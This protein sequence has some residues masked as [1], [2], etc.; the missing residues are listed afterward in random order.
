MITSLTLPVTISSPPTFQHWA[1]LCSVSRCCISLCPWLSVLLSSMYWSQLSLW[2]AL[3]PAHLHSHPNCFNP[4]SPY[5]HILILG[6][7]ITKEPRLV[8]VCFCLF[9]QFC[10]KS[11]FQSTSKWSVSLVV[12]PCDVL[13]Y[14]GLLREEKSAGVVK[15]Q[16]LHKQGYGPS[17]WG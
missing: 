4:P 5:W 9:F 17:L 11:P 13:A 16:Q 3:S 8:F 2:L 14:L 15:N 12:H 7:R 10:S 1:S 6:K